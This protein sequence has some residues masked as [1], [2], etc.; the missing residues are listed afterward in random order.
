MAQVIL[1][2]VGGAIGGPAGAMIGA[3]LGSMVDAAAIN[4]LTPPRP[5]GPRIRE[6]SLMSTAEGAPMA[7]AF[8]RVRVGG[9]MIWAARFRERRVEGRVGGGKGGPRTVD[10]RY[11]LSFA[12]A[13]CEG[14]IDGIGRI[15]ADGRP[16]DVAG[17][18]LRLHRG[19]E[20]QAPDPLIE[21]IEGA[22]PAYRGCAYLVFEDLPL[23][24]WGD[25]PPQLSVEVFRRPRGARTALE[26]KLKG[27]CL[28]PG[29]GEF[30][31]A[32]DIVRRRDG[33]TRTATENLNNVE[34]RAD[35]LV[36]L[37]QLQAQLPNLEEV[38]LV[39]AWFG[40]SLDAG[41]C[42]IRPGVEHAVKATA[43]FAW[44][45]GGVGRV[46]AHLVS[47]ADGGPAYG[48]TPADQSVLQAIAELKRRGL[49]VTLYPFILM[50]CDGYPWRGRISGEAADVEGF[51]GAYG[52]EDITV[53]DGR[54]DHDGPSGDWGLRRMVL[55]HARLAALAGGV[56]G[57]LIGSELRGLTTIRDGEGGYP[58][59]VALRDLA[60]DCRAVLGAETAIGYAADWSEQF[61]VSEPPVV[62]CR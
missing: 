15:W 4:A 10:Y 44:R 2:S 49:K 11:S 29:A 54:I 46:G 45:A 43:P 18:T 31:L 34:G 8:G 24:A 21:A 59:V 20:D 60:A 19:T 6:L 48:G 12:V 50:D 35:L 37:D 56:D 47:A 36:S 39:V 22:A 5:I 30:A 42:E 40:T 3:A 16:M 14:P 23:E 27:V 53:H 9:Q 13:L 32:T 25:R 33:L 52:P 7:A 58:A 55:H 62:I 61:D 26:D 28:I 38:T 41:T 1:S 51:F 17:V 57:F